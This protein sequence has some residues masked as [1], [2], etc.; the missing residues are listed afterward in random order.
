MFQQRAEDL[1][2]EDI[3]LKGTKYT[4]YRPAT[5]AELCKLKK[6]HGDKAMIVGYTIMAG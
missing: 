3:E 5:V 1:M 6:Q 4:L 2:N